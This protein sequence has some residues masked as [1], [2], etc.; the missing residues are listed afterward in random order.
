MVFSL[1]TLEIIKVYAGDNGNSDVT[2]LMTGGS[3]GEMTTKAPHDTP[4]LSKEGE[5]LLFLVRTDEGHYLVSG[6]YQ[7]LGKLDKNGRISFSNVDEATEG[8]NN[9]SLSELTHKLV[10]PAVSDSRIAVVDTPTRTGMQ[11]VMR[12]RMNK[13]YDFDTAITDSE[14]I[15][16]ISILSWLCE[17]ENNTFFSA[18]IN[19]SLKG[20]IPESIVLMQGGTSQW[21]SSTYPLFKVG[22]HLFLFLK[23]AHGVEYENA[24]WILG[25]FTT[26]MDVVFTE[27]KAYLMDRHGII[28]GSID[29][30]MGIPDE[31]FTSVSTTITGDL[32]EKIFAADPLLIQLNGVHKGVIQYDEICEKIGDAIANTTW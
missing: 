23:E 25:G 8:I 20:T 29:N 18:T 4:L 10:S 2:V 13:R 24:Y 15:A 1:F 28:S 22:D 26:V 7:G 9:L 16:D 21:T 14:A 31:Q 11:G 3:T 30:A 12:P 32:R 6:G 5:Y 19:S 27:N 17:D